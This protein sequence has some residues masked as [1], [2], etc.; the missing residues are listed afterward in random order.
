MISKFWGLGFEHPPPSPD[1]R[2]SNGQSMGNWVIVECIPGNNTQN[3]VPVIG[4]CSLS[5]GFLIQP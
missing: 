1:N 5:G 2:E 3:I 4:A